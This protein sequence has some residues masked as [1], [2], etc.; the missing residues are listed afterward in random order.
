[1]NQYFLLTI[2][3]TSTGSPGTYA[4]ERKYPLNQ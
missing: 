3:P 2:N 1:M 4:I